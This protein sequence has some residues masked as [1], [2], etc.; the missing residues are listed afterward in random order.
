MKK[1]ISCLLASILVLTP[2][3]PVGAGAV[4]P[5]IIADNALE[6]NPNEPEMNAAQASGQ[7]AEAAAIGQVDVSVIA[8]LVLEGDIDFQVSLTGQ[9][10]QT[11]TLK[12]DAKTEK[13]SRA[14]ARFE[15]LAPAV[16]TL[17]VT[18][19]G[20]ASYTQ[21]ITVGHNAYGLE[22]VAGI[23]NPDAYQNA[24]PG[25]LQI[26]DVNGDGTV[27]EADKKML[28]EAIDAKPETAAANEDLN[29]DGEINL[30]DLEYFT[31]GY[32][33]DCVGMQSTLKVGV[34]AAITNVAC[35]EDTMITEGVLQ[36]LLSNEGTVTLSREDSQPIGKDSPVSIEFTLPEDNASSLVG[37]MTIESSPEDPISSASFEIVYSEDGKENT[38]VEIPFQ[39]GINYLLNS[40]NVSVTQ[41]SQ[42]GAIHID[43]GKQVA[44]K[45]VTLKIFGTKSSSN[46]VEISKVEFL[47]DMLSR[48]PEPA[49]DIPQNP[50]AVMGSKTFSVNWEACT[51]VTGYEV[52]VSEGDNEEIT[53]VVGNSLTVTGVSWGPKGKLENGKTYMVK[54]RAVNGAWRSGYSKTVE[55]KP[56]TTKKPDKP[57]Y[58]KAVGKYK[59]IDVSWKDMED[60]DWYHVYYKEKDAENF[61]KIEQDIVSNSYT[62]SELKDKTSYI[63]YVTGVNKIGES[64]PSLE[65]SADTADITPAKMYRYKLLNSA[66]DGQISNHIKSAS[67]V[68]G[69]MIDSPEDEISTSGNKTAWG[70]V[71]N[72]PVSYFSFNSW[73]GGGY[74]NLGN[75]GLFYEFDEAYEIQDIALQEVS[76]QGTSYGYANIRYWDEENEG[77]QATFSQLGMR[78]MTDSQNRVYYRIHLPKK[79]KT[80]KI[81]FGIARS[82]ASGTI[83][84]SEV[85]FYHYDSLED[86]IMGLYE[87][88]L[89]T[90]LKED[91]T[92]E[93]INAL[94]ERVNTK[95]AASDEYHPDKDMLERELKTA[96]DILNSIL[97]PSVHIHNSITTSD[98]NRGFGGLNAWQPLGVTAAAGE[99]ITVYVGH[100][101]KK[102]GENTSLQLVATQYHSEATPMFS[103]VRTL[104]IGRND[105]TLPRIGSLNTEAGGALYVQY[106][107]NNASD[108]Y[109]VRVS[110]GVQVP[111]LDLYQVTDAAER[112][113]RAEAYV[114]QLDEYVSQME[115]KH[116][117]IHQASDNKLVQYAYSKQDCILG[118]T[119]ILLDTMMLSLPA[120]QI[121]AGSGSGSIAERAGKIVTSMDAMEEMMHLFYQHKGLNKTDT[122]VTNKKA[123]FPV[124]H[125]N[126]RYQRMFA[127]AFM[128]ASGNHIG[129]EYGSAPGMISGV[130]VQK[131]A[132][133]KWISGQYFGWGIA[134]EIGH[135]INQ[136]AY[137]IAEIT[138]NYFSVLA[139]AKDRN[140]SVRFQYDKVYEKVTSNTKGRANNVFTQLGMYWQLHLAYDD[141]YNY[142]TYEKYDE[143]LKS[144]FFARVDTYARDTSKA[145][146]PG[147]TAL[148]LGDTDQS[149]MRLSCAA[150]EKNL[151][152]FFER[153]GMVP[154]EQTK[155]YAEQFEEET[156]AIYYVNDD[157]RVYRLT[158]A[159]S[160]LSTNGTVEGVGD[161]TT[162]VV[163]NKNKN[164][165]DF[166]L[167]AS[168]NILKEDIHGYEIVRCM[169]SGG[170]VSKEVAG[171]TT[172]NTFSDHITTVNNRVVTYEIT[173]IDHYMNRS[174]VKTLPSLK[175]EH[176][177][178]I[179]KT[180]WTL[181]TNGLTPTQKVESPS[182][183]EE[184]P[185][186]PAPENPIVKAADNDTNTAYTG[187][188]GANAEVLLEFNQPLTITAFKYTPG[189]GTPIGDYRISVCTEDG[190]WTEAAAGTFR[191][192]QP[193]T[194]YFTNSEQT[195]G[196]IAAYRAI[197]VKLAIADPA[198]TEVSIAELDVLGI[199]GDNVDFRRTQDADQTTAIGRLEKDFQY[200]DRTDDII[201]KGSIVFTGSY[202]GNPAY[203]VVLLYDQNGENV[204]VTQADGSLNAAQVILAEVPTTGNIQ[205]VSDG[206]WLYWV[207]PDEN[208]QVDLPDVTK[209]R[210]ELYRVDN[211]ET[212]EGQRMVSDSLFAD[213]PKELPPLKLDNLSTQ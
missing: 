155:A 17:T 149:L 108:Q 106:T 109:A 52:L 176:D 32:Q 53:P 79:I 66:E 83:T 59:A 43:F 206:T 94:R 153:W 209:V 13:P 8:G 135:C 23:V 36:S 192:T 197:A 107:G 160:S 161:G 61:T 7:Q 42:T 148:T 119:D 205:D 57:D 48:I 200:G 6:A 111:I 179:D 85:Y 93:T 41:D 40:E 195:N 82:V 51:N 112:Q 140:D 75:H 63:I 202:K 22:L 207:E 98:V 77:K 113:T 167:E 9:E 131:D 157:S 30:A 122:A 62:I 182:G 129:I 136:G 174:A 137:A 120:Q 130:P 164:Q 213:M 24:H 65:A 125:L 169:T 14:E 159:G 165:V 188:I 54:V 211:A 177:G 3:L 158:H 100:N 189:S 133:G 110:G 11:I 193:Q 123:Q 20:F 89:H 191:G 49:L 45:K 80:R 27:D 76:V 118:A 81:Q 186:A 127:G 146:A 212:N 105:I 150:A 147:G 142:K 16:Y 26:G 5:E 28:T 96:E 73:D 35:G 126:I 92:Q 60:T 152:D 204:G 21:E 184:D 203:N 128:Y 151:L 114:E 172:G 68:N 183:D 121:Q 162:A 37:G 69:S 208:G 44:V 166:T 102:T 99:E 117:E 64:D 12:K 55:A 56:E 210:A 145:P 50:T 97:S 18:A 34:P 196:N 185:C 67:I 124:G 10:T 84:I 173:L 33:A 25:I 141:G 168:D 178:A 15:H 143:Q 47:G 74:N 29:R 163:N 88:D 91:V 199:T 144:L 134:H 104:K 103:V 201:P 187:T 46:L 38:T 71:D 156:R 86:E 101:S 139:Q 4:S 194:V 95:D 19:P 116:A 72:N 138:N 170:K 39:E 132:N 115:A 70:T 154:D 2:C 181:S 58:V 171:F 180:N 90:V 198:G 78:R 190:S 1:L 31:K 87:D 175:I